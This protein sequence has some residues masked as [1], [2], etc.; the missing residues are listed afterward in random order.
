[1]MLTLLLE[2]A[3]R[4][5]VLG[6]A[7]WCGL[8]LFHVRGVQVERIVW[9]VVLIAALAMPLLMQWSTVAVPTP[10]VPAIW[11][12]TSTPVL[13]TEATQVSKL[14]SPSDAGPAPRNWSTIL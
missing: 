7:V 6:L 2:S 9:T 10:A 4:S 14:L 3:A 13:S 11:S 1:M 5:L 12:A 8:K